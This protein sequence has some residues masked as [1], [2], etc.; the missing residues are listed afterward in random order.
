MFLCLRVHQR[1]DR[2]TENVRRPLAVFPSAFFRP[3]YP[4]GSGRNGHL[5][6]R[7]VPCADSSAITKQTDGQT[8]DRLADTNTRLTLYAFHNFTMKAVIVIVHRTYWQPQTLLTSKSL[9][10]SIEETFL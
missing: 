6:R 1:K 2:S 4:R 9:R 8:A 5:K 10:D 7:F 3:Q